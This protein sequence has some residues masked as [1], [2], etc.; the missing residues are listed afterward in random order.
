MERAIA[1]S[2]LGAIVGAYGTFIG[3]GGGFVLM[4]LLVLL[5]PA[6]GRETLAAISLCVVFF[7]ALS[8]T[9]AY[10]RMKRVDYRSGLLFA[11]ATAPGAIIGALVTAWLPMHVFD[12]ILGAVLVAG[13]VVVAVRPRPKARA[14]V[15]ETHGG[16][17]RSLV[18]AE[19]TSYRWSFRPALGVALS[20]VVGFVSSVLGVGGG[21]THVPILIFLLT[22]PVHVAT[23]TSHFVLAAM[24]LVGTLVHIASGDFA[25]GVHRTLWL[26][27]GVIAGAQFGA[28]LSSRVRGRWITRGLALALL[29]VGLRVLLQA[30]R[31]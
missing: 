24:A 2:L 31:S 28:W 14:D 25:H 17:V 29:L 27:V 9:A 7:N 20:L 18:D 1:L 11:A 15:S 22:F 8:G 4:P 16:M 23:A 13:A 5:W 19:G 30:L 3:A 6:E 21:F 26:S 12:A 10:A